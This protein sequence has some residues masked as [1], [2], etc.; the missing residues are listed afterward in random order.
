MRLLP[1]YDVILSLPAGINRSIAWR[2]SV[3]LNPSQSGRL[4]TCSAQ[5]SMQSV[6][7]TR[8]APRVRAAQQVQK[9]PVAG[10][11]RHRTDQAGGGFVR[12]KD[13][14]PPVQRNR[15]AATGEIGFGTGKL[16]QVAIFRRAFL[17]LR[18]RQIEV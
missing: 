17:R 4:R 1:L 6:C 13:P 3:F 12:D 9:H 8:G 2:K 14:V 16:A 11:A 10:P 15:L 5:N 7:V 18:R